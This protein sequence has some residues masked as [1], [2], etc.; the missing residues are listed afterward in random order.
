[1]TRP[2]DVSDASP[3]N[4]GHPI[5]W[6]R[7][8]QGLR[9]L[10]ILLVVLYHARLPI[11]GG[12][13]G[14]DVFFV[15]SGYVITASV[16]R[17]VIAGRFSAKDFYWRRFRRL[18][19]ALSVVV[20]AVLILSFAI[21]S[22]ISNQSNT[23]WMAVGSM[24]SISNVV[25]YFSPE[26]YFYQ[27]LSPNPLL[28]TWSL[29]VEEQFYFGFTI[30]VLAVIFLAKRYGALNSKNILIGALLTGIFCSFAISAASSFRTPGTLLYVPDFINP[31]FAF[32]SPITR[33]WEFG[34]GSLLALTGWVICG[35]RLASIVS[36]LGIAMILIAAFF[37]SEET[38]FPGL[39][40]A[41]P[42][43]GTLLIILAGNEQAG[44]LF[45]PLNSGVFTRLGSVSYSWYLWHWPIIIFAV[46]ALGAS[47]WVSLTAAFVSIIPSWL[48]LKYIETPNLRIEWKSLKSKGAPF[49]KWF[50]PPLILG[51]LLIFLSTNLWFNQPLKN[52][53][54]QTD[55]ALL[56][57]DCTDLIADFGIGSL[58]C[59]WPSDSEGDP[60]YLVGDSTAAQYANAIHESLMTSGR[61]LTVAVHPGCPFLGV[62]LF[63]SNG[64]SFVDNVEC[65]KANLEFRKILLSSPPGLVVL[66]SSSVPFYSS[67]QAVGVGD[68]P[69]SKETEHKAE[70]LEVGLGSLIDSLQSDGHSV[71]V[72][73]STPAFFVRAGVYAPLDQWR[74]SN[75]A[76]LALLEVDESCGTSRSIKQL[77]SYQGMS[78]EA[79]ARATGARSVKLLDPRSTLCSNGGCPTNNENLW[80]F[81]DGVHLSETGVD[82]MGPE[83]DVLVSQG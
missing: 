62:K 78:R 31:D 2:T 14:V 71:S 41:I 82:L 17:R 77:D 19:P 8:I 48:S 45:S 43:L 57:V 1:M 21:Q 39:V 20:L 55:A 9:G 74:P 67:D 70:D 12:F 40:V 63:Y 44:T 25:A 32:Y 59:T 60:V 61:S 50:A 35:R 56:K 79:I 69:P 5:G 81:R 26:G 83:L 15:I 28:N 37:I 23:G 6:R 76:G 54:Q 58:V 66:A 38:V 22:P 33:A 29:S 51:F 10:A 27:G 52:M 47:L 80:M 36:V 3:V 53:A 11:S 7:D 75:C 30:V 16:M 42:V 68:Q 65:Q 24:L 73:Q 64:S 13:V 72:I 4:A 34:L 46:A 49:A 18:I